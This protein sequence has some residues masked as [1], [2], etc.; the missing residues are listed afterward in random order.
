MFKF[1]IV[2]DFY[3][4]YFLYVKNFLQVVLLMYT[5]KPPL[6]NNLASL[7][8]TKLSIVLYIIRTGLLFIITLNYGILLML[9]ELVIFLIQKKRHSRCDKKRH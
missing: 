5:K 4:F 9:T 6:Q 8:T 2:S 1:A 3:F 7:I